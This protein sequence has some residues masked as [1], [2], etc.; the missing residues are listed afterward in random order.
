MRW[1]GRRQSDNVEDL[2]GRGGRSGGGIG[3]GGGRIRIPMGGSGMGGRL[4]GA[5]RQVDEMD[6]GGFGLQGV[7]TRQGGVE[8]VAQLEGYAAA[9]LGQLGDAELE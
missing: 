5:R 9:L 2:R 6:G 4:R 8:L 3:R 1:K 7:E